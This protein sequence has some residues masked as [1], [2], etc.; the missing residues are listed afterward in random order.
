MASNYHTRRML[1][2]NAS[3]T[4]MLKIIRVALCDTHVHHPHGDSA[5]YYWPWHQTPLANNTRSR[6]ALTA[7]AILL[8]GNRD[9][10]LLTHL[11]YSS[12][13]P[14]CRYSRSPPCWYKLHRVG[15]MCGTMSYVLTTRMYR[16]VS[17]GPAATSRWLLLPAPHR[18]LRR[19][20]AP[21]VLLLGLPLPPAPAMCATAAELA[22]LGADGSKRL[23][24]RW[25]R[26]S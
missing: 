5:G 22:L 9:Q 11:H 19:L 24:D 20:E 23:T 18:P 12:T 15:G 6:N 10:K 7:Q 2:C 3:T 17:G 14:T 8:H 26:N 13:A 4:L 25:H 16:L 21:A 1:A